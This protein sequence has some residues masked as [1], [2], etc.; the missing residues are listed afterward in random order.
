MTIDATDCRAW[1]EEAKASWELRPLLERE[2]DGLV[3]VGF[4]LDLYARIPLDV[5]PGPGREA[6]VVALWERLREIADSLL[7]FAGPD[8]RIEVAPFEAAARLRPETQFAAEMLLTARVYHGANLLTP[9]R[10]GEKERLRPVE[11][12]LRDL[13]LR[14]GSW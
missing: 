1:A 11:E 2:K 13:G 10:E 5:E 9:V 14:P 4:E 6:A 3:Q 7:P 8:A 12:R